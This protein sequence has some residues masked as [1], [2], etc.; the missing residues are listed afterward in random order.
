MMPLPLKNSKQRVVCKSGVNNNNNLLTKSR[1]KSNKRG[2][3]T[4]SNKREK[5]SNLTESQTVQI[6]SFEDLDRILKTAQC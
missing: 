6:R 1:T 3:R 4:K 2:G 5:E